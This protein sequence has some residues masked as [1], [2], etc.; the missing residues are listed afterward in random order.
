MTFNII[1]VLVLVVLGILLLLAEI[2]LLPGISVAGI[3]GVIFL[4]GGIVYSYIYLGATAG[5]S[6]LVVSILLLGAAF[7]WLVKSKSIQKIGLKADI[8][9][10]V[11]NSALKKINAGDAGV[12]LSRLNPIGN[13]LINDITVEGKSFDGEFIEE[14]VEIEVVRVETYNV[15]VKE[16]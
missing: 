6:T 1:I 12:T 14:D 15:L 4:G 9:E 5:T 2:F 16:K 11:D 10:T 8:S 3:G 7:A 13:V